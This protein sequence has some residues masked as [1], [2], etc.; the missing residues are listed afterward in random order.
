MINGNSHKL[1]TLKRYLRLAAPSGE[2]AGVSQSRRIEGQFNTTRDA[3]FFSTV[4][5]L[6]G[7]G[8]A[9][10]PDELLEVI[11]AVTGFQYE[12]LRGD[13]FPV[14]ARTFPGDGEPVISERIRNSVTSKNLT[15]LLVNAAGTAIASQPQAINSLGRIDAA[16]LVVII[17]TSRTIE[18]AEDVRQH[19]ARMK[20]R[21]VWVLP[22]E[23]VFLSPVQFEQPVL[24]DVTSQ[25]C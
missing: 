3:K 21:A 7:P 11:Q 1:E 13:P 16:G 23:K 22:A 2:V 18:V 5:L 10:Y 14:I 8:V 6:A 19:L 9:S 12:V 24:T 25:D 15:E 4:T 20:G 17:S